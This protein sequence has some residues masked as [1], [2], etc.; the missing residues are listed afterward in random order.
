[1]AGLIPFLFDR[2]DKRAREK[3]LIS[4]LGRPEQQMPQITAP[5]TQGQMQTQPQMG[6][7]QPGTGLLGGEFGVPGF[8]AR[9]TALPGMEG[10][11]DLLAGMQPKGPD[12]QRGAF[13]SAS[14]G[15]GQ[16]FT[17]FTG[18]DG[19]VYRYMG[20]GRIVP[21]PADS[22]LVST[23]VSGGTEVLPESLRKRLF[24]SE[25]QK[26][27]IGRMGSALAQ[28]S[29]LPN[30]IG[31]PGLVAEKLGGLLGQ[32]PG[33]G[34]E[35]ERAFTEAVTGAPPEENKAMRSAFIDTSAAMLTAI[36][37]EESGRYTKEERALATESLGALKLTST[38][39]TAR[40]GFIRALQITLASQRREQRN[41]GQ[42][43]EDIST[44]E[45][46]TALGERLVKTGMSEADAKTII[47]ELI[48]IEGFQ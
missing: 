5:T 7:P 25:K 32:I 43:I 45:G 11:V 9:T 2:A 37:G 4:L 13:Y 21:A 22:I 35:L 1:M 14:I 10:N 33:A 47:R 12:L 46:I 15:K 28:M 40:A 34:P 36:S 18:K 23:Q 48:R 38:L 26:T 41:A 44:R 30:S 31:V 16:R 20:D 24:E 29:E 8:V 39:A 17:G 3:G 19:T 27:N 6:P 42:P